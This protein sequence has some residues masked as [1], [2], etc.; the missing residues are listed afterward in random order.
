MS[1]VDF[2]ETVTLVFVERPWREMTLA[3]A[4]REVI[5]FPQ[6][7][8]VATTLIVGERI[9]IRTYSEIVT[10]YSRHDF[11]EIIENDKPKRRTKLEL[12]A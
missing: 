11:P 7:V 12:I 5:V 9:L 4:V 3:D 6:K 2:N 1:D 10:L 8:D